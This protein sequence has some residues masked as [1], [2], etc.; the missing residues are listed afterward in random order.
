MGHGAKEVVDLMA[1]EQ[2]VPRLPEGMVEWAQC[3]GQH[4]WRKT[5]TF[6]GKASLVVLPLQKGQ[7]FL[8]TMPR[9]KGGGSIPGP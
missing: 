1:L 8:G 7:A 3:P 9:N 4:H 6:G 5:E 2:F